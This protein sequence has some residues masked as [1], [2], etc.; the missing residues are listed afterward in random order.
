MTVCLCTSESRHWSW[1]TLIFSST[2]FHSFILSLCSIII[3]T[4]CG[5]RCFSCK[6]VQIIQDH[7]DAMKLVL[8]T[9]PPLVMHSLVSVVVNQMLKVYA[10]HPANLATL[11]WA[12][13]MNSDVFL[14]SATVMHLSVNQLL[15]SIARP[16][17]LHSLVITKNGPLKLSKPNKKSQ[18]TIIR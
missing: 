16:L 2:C 6:F 1:V 15:D 12:R 10:V 9:T 17:N 11:T 8:W 13:T 5:C 4:S 18:S 14:A 7:V 3:F